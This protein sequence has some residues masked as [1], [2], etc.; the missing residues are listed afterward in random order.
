[1][2]KLV[3]YIVLVL[4]SFL[5]FLGCSRDAVVYLVDQEIIGDDFRYGD[6]YRLS[7]LREYKE[8]V[9][10]CNAPF[11]G[12]KAPV[13]LYLSGD[14]FT[15]TGR[16][17]PN[18]YASTGF[19]R[20]AVN[21][22]A[23]NLQLVKG[24]K[25]LVI[26]T[27]ERHTRERFALKPWMS[28]TPAPKVRAVAQKKSLWG[29]LLDWEIPYR[30]EM[31]EAVLF[32]S[33][34]ILAIK[35]WKAGFHKQVFDKVDPKVGVV[36]E[37]LVYEM[38][39]EPGVSSVFDPVEE[40]ELARIVQH[41]NET[42]ERYRALGFDEVYISVIPNKSSLLLTQD[43]RYNRLVERIEQHPALEVPV[44]SVWEEFRQKDYYL[45]GDSHWNCEGQ[46]VWVD[47]VNRILA[48]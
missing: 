43:A 31:H 2:G 45:K 21:T 5:W 38:D 7:N 6:L 36:N 8:E 20:S 13:T 46:Q 15:E 26:E 16:L 12:K 39:L 29:R 19:F 23:Q 14:S 10:K 30:E 27:V 44:I 34:F 48:E 28:W 40:E 33:D 24:K 32:S 47:K 9:V 22:P 35:E 41:M 11:A 1:M 42:R 4:A 3:K 18:A 37:H 17:H 25:I